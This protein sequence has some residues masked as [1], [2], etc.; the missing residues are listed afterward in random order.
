MGEGLI[1]DTL[2]ARSDAGALPAQEILAGYPAAQDGDIFVAQSLY[3]F[4]PCRRACQG[5]PPVSTQDP[6]P[7]Q[8]G[9]AGQL[10][11][12]PTH[13]PGMAGKARLPGHGAIAAHRARRNGGNNLVDGVSE[14][15]DQK[16]SFKPQVS[17]YKESMKED[18]R[19][20][21][22]ACPFVWPVHHAG[23]QLAACSLQ[24][25]EARHPYRYNGR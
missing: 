2:S 19:A 11:H 6:V 12:Q 10:A 17:S 9:V 8:T 16:G 15:R 1:I 20:G 24:L 14:C 13:K 5:Y 21:P 18:K 23:L 25:S 4:F 7:G 3:L 22:K